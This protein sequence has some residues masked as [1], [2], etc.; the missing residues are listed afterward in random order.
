MQHAS[1][2]LYNSLRPAQTDWKEEFG[3]WL[4]VKTGNSREKLKVANMLPAIAVTVICA[5]LGF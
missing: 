5:F 3:N 2:V 1:S 4:K